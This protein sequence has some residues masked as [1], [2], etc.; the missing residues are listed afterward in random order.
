MG[1]DILT[2]FFG[3]A[4]F[5]NY[6]CMKKRYNMV[7]FL[8][9]QGLECVLDKALKFEDDG[10]TSFFHKPTSTINYLIVP[11]DEVEAFGSS[12]IFKGEESLLGLTKG[13]MKLRFWRPWI[14]ANQVHWQGWVQLVL[15]LVIHRIESFLQLQRERVSPRSYKRANEAAF[16]ETMNNSE[17]GSLARAGTIN[18]AIGDSQD[19]KPTLIGNPSCTGLMMIILSTGHISRAHLNPS[20]TI[21]FLALHH[22]HGYRFPHTRRSFC[23]DGNSNLERPKVHIFDHHLKVCDTKIKVP[24]NH[25]QCTDKERAEWKK[26]SITLKIH[27]LCSTL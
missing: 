13:Q 6:K 22:F 4:T 2:M 11:L 26:L 19:R 14:I 24:A 10:K 9:S 21:G 3:G 16:L 8:Y 7:D 15:L 18:V 20:L 23:T 27:T 12:C 25:K 1:K 5:R 17:P